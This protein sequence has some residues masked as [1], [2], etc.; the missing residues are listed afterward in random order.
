MLLYNHI[1]KARLQSLPMVIA[2]YE[3]NL[4]FQR[5]SIFL[6]NHIYWGDIG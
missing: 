2:E 3:P 4:W 1:A 5:I 6:L